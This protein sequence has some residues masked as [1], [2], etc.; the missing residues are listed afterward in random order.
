MVPVTTMEEIPVLG[1][2]ERAQL[3]DSLRKAEEDIKAGKA[4][5]YVAKKFRDR[6]IRI[7]RRAKP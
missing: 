7:F 5:D 6:L 1:N 4:V 2:D 3:L